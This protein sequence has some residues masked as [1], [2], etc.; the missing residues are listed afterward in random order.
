[1]SPCRRRK[2]EEDLGQAET[3]TQF[4]STASEITNFS[5]PYGQEFWNDPHV[6]DS[7]VYLWMEDR[8]RSTTNRECQ[9]FFLTA[10]ETIDHTM[11]TR[12]FAENMEQDGRTTKTIP[13]I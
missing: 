7:N 4:F 5:Q 10:L 1:M 2:K 9:T 13:T 11:R 8:G 3:I 6:R 12:N